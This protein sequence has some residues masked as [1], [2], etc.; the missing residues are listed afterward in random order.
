[1][2]RDGILALLHEADNYAA[3]LHYEPARVYLVGAGALVLSR[4]IQ[5]DTEDLDFI[6]LSSFDG[7]KPKAGRFHQF[8]SEHVI[9]E[10]TWAFRAGR[11]GTSTFKAVRFFVQDVHHVLLHKLAR[12]LPHDLQD[13]E[14]AAAT[15]PCFNDAELAQEVRWSLE[16]PNRTAMEPERLRANYN[17]LAARLRWLPLLEAVS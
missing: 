12:G 8:P 1:M 3:S 10:P 4:L 15:H 11:F 9:C 5:R 17:T 16:N 13:V 7:F 6:S 14:Q 2:N